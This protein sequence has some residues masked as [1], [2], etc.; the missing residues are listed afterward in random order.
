MRSCFGIIV[1]ALISIGNIMYADAQ[2]VNQ[3]GLKMVKRLTISKHNIYGKKDIGEAIG[4]TTIEFTYDSEKRLTGIEW[5][6]IPKHVMHGDIARFTFAMQGNTMDCKKYQN[7]KRKYNYEY[8]FN[9]NK[10]GKITYFKE[11]THG[12]H[13]GGRLIYE[14]KFA[15]IGGTYEYFLSKYSALLPNSSEWEY[16]HS[17]RGIKLLSIDG[18]YH[19]NTYEISNDMA[20]LCDK[21]ERYERYYTDKLNDMNFDICYLLCGYNSEFHIYECLIS[22]EWIGAYSK[23][24]VDYIKVPKARL[25]KCFYYTYD[26]DDNIVGI[27]MTEEVTYKNGNESK[28]KIYHVDIEYYYD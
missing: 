6:N 15:Y 23:N 2:C 5:V 3:D 9:I 10:Y 7:G 27:D 18:N 20:V 25:K 21:P 8:K 22:S 16:G 26:N 11:I 24:M 4:I 17:W 13:G 12:S 28:M 14:Y 1:A 19:C